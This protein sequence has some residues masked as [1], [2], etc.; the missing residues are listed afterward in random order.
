MRQ[1]LLLSLLCGLFFQSTS[2]AADHAISDFDKKAAAT[3]YSCLAGKDVKWETITPQQ[4]KPGLTRFEKNDAKK[5]ATYAL[6]FG[7]PEAQPDLRGFYRIT[8]GEDV[9]D[10]VGAG[11]KVVRTDPKTGAEILS[12]RIEKSDAAKYLAIGARKKIGKVVLTVSQ[13]RPLDEAV[14][15]AAAD[16]TKRFDTFL[17]QANRN[18]L[19][20]GQIK[21]ILTSREGQP[22]LGNGEPLLFSVDDMNS[23]VVT[24]RVDLTGPDGEAMTDIKHVSFQ[25]GGD[26]A[27]VIGAKINDKP[28]DLTKRYLEKEP[29][30]SL[31]LTLTIPAGNTPEMMN[32]LYNSIATDQPTPSQA[33]TLKVGAAM[34]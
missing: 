26:F 13:R 2:F 1:V 31:T 17:A 10:A 22:E 21:L 12:R 9:S 34:K 4:M 16:I 14:D 29:K 23:E 3:L 28:V 30:S 7:I 20:G 33:L 11:W 15:V 8:L 18:K 27:P 25:I 6:N 5:S 24:I 19:F 32:L